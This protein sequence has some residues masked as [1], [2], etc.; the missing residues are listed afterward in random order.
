MASTYTRNGRVQSS[1][2]I[3]ERN[4]FEVR[5][6]PCLNE[7]LW[8]LIY[9]TGNKASTKNVSQQFDAD[10]ECIV[11][12]IKL[13]IYLLMSSVCVC[14]FISTRFIVI[15]GYNNYGIIK[16]YCDERECINKLGERGKNNLMIRNYFDCL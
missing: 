7:G 3:E 14:V 13:K 1:E 16:F 6:C 10:Y 9:C 4:R 5:F 12:S 8:K 2:H 15:F 11:L